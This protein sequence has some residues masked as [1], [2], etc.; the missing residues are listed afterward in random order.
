VF[1]RATSAIRSAA[2]RIGARDKISIGNVAQV[3]S[4]DD[5]QGAAATCNHRSAT[6]CSSISNVPDRNP[7]R[8]DVRITANEGT[9]GTVTDLVSA[10]S[11][12]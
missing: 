1:V 3:N 6:C 5:G 4:L 8:L 7:R 10:T 9:E 12:W 11:P 2:F